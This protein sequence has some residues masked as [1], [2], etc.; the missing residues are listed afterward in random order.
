MFERVGFEMYET[1]V[2]FINVDEKESPYVTASFYDQ[3]V[4][5]FAQY[6]FDKILMS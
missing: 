2:G 1:V 3:P 6:A 4:S 5:A